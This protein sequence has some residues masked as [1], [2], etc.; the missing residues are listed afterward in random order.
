MKYVLIIVVFLIGVAGIFVFSFVNDQ[1]QLPEGETV[2]VEDDTIQVMTDR[3]I[4]ETDGVKHSIPLNEILSGGPGKDGIP[5]IDEPKFIDIVEADEFLKD[6]DV[7]LAIS[8]KG[9]NRFYPY[10]VLVWHE[11]V[12]DIIADDPVLVT[13][14]PLCQTGIAFSRE[15]EFGVSGKLWQ[16]NLLMY[17]RSSEEESLWSQILGEAVLGPKT[18]TKLDIVSSNT[19]L[20]GDW[21]KKNPSTVVLSKDTGATRPYGTDP[22]EGYYTSDN[23][24]FGA[25]FNDDRL[26]PKG[27]VFG[28]EVGGRYKAYHSDA[29]KVGE[30]TDTFSEEVITIQKSDI[31]EVAMYIGENQLQYISGFWFSWLAVHPETELYK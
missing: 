10:Q 7:G 26:H 25:T 16:S 20:Y 12:N 29:L 22:Y 23:V 21:K 31:G 28:I 13:Y 18:G 15:V 1:F 14:C 5:S 24:S 6:N 8:Y 11:I 27:F 9:E 30:T 17:D 4:S 3:E 19:V 2:L